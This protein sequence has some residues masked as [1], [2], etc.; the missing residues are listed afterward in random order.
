MPLKPKNSTKP[1]QK[2]KSVKSTKEGARL[3]RAHSNEP[4]DSAVIAELSRRFPAAALGQKLEAL[5]E[6]MTPPIMTKDGKIISRPD[7]STR[8]RAIDLTLSYLVGKPIERTMSLRA[9][10]PMTMEDIEKM[11]SDS[12]ALCS[13]LVAVLSRIQIKQKEGK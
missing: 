1:V 5:M 2:K 6:A 11:A 4:V 13:T 3:A 12:P 8:L 9:E 10:R 7:Y